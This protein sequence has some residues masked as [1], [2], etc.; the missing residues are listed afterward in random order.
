M[1]DFRSGFISLLHLPH[2]VAWIQERPKLVP[3]ARIVSPTPW[4]RTLEVIKSCVRSIKDDW[5]FNGCEVQRRNAALNRSD[6]GFVYSIGDGHAEAAEVAGQ[7]AL[8]E[9]LGGF[10]RVGTEKLQGSSIDA[11]ELR[12][13]EQRVRMLEFYQLKF[14]PLRNDSVRTVLAND[15]L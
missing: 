3:Q 5:E 14:R 12:E 2:R 8:A 6:G 10:K 13:N 1:R 7:N 11:V 9:R 4:W 15:V